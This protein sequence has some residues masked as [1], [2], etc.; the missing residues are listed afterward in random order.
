MTARR[1]QQ[2]LCAL[3]VAALISFPAAASGWTAWEGQS[4]ETPHA[5]YSGEAG[6][7]GTL[8]SCD[9]TGRLKAVLTVE[10]G[11]L[12]DLFK[13][14]AP[15]GREEKAVMQIGERAPYEAAFRIV[16]AMKVIETRRHSV[17]A[18]FFNASIRGEP[19]TLDL[20]TAGHIETS[21]PAP[22]AT[23]KAFANTCRDARDAA[24]QRR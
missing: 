15:Y 12:P 4:E 21:L 17:A 23:F 19:V 13:R 2:T 11:Y 18:K 24:P 16:P 7:Y 14:N 1:T 10:P 20:E 5:I 6:T 9:A 22:D 8:L 3:T